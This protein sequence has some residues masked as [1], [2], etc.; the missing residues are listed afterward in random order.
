MSRPLD[1]E[2]AL[3]VL[4]AHLDGDLGVGLEFG[5][6]GFSRNDVR[7]PGTTGTPLCS[8]LRREASLS[9]ITSMASAV[10]PMKTSPAFS[11]A[12]QKAGFSDRKP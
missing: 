8:I 9:P 5:A 1:C 12:R 6:V 11:T 4:E 2:E 10:G 7:V 3:R